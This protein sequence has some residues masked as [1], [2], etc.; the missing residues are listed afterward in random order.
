[1]DIDIQVHLNYIQACLYVNHLQMINEH[2]KKV[3]NL[4]ESI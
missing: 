1:M 4:N 2:F 3:M